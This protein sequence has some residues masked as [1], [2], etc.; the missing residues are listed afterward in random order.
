VLG[1]SQSLVL[2]EWDD[3]QRGH[4]LQWLTE[5]GRRLRREGWMSAEDAQRRYIVAAGPIEL[6]GHDPVDV[7]A[8]ADLADAIASLVQG[9]LPETKLDGRCILGLPAR[10][11]SSEDL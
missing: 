1:S 4:L 11:P 10:P 2:H 8:A 7:T 6:R 9:D 5:A 3:E